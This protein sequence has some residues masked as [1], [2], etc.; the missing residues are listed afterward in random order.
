MPRSFVPAG[1]RLGRKKKVAPPPTLAGPAALRF[2]EPPDQAWGRS[3]GGLGTKV[4]L[5]G[6]GHGTVLAVWVTPGQRHESQ[7]F[8]VVMLRAQRPR[9]AG[10]P[11]WPRRVAGDK[12]YS[13]PGI[14]QWLQRHHIAAGSASR[15][16]QPRAAAFDPV[17]YRRRNL[18]ERVV[19]WYK[20]DRALGTRYEKLAVNYVALWLIAI[21]EK[22]VRKYAEKLQ[23]GLSERA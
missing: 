22:L 23:T 3:Q 7:A 20:E 4:H 19:G 1:R 21:I 17:A 14:R 12:G 2:A 13:Y 11:R 6:E 10:R 15:K 9:R 5:V 16:N 8:S 18:I